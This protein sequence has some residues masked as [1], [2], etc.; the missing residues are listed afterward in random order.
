MNTIWKLISC[1]LN[2]SIIRV[3]FAEKINVFE[4]YRCRFWPPRYLQNIP[5]DKKEIKR[6]QLKLFRLKHFL[7]RSLFMHIGGKR[8]S[9]TNVLKW[10]RVPFV[11]PTPPRPPKTLHLKFTEKSQL[12]PPPEFLTTF[13][14]CG[15]KCFDVLS[16]LGLRIKLHSTV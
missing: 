13:H 3:K 6:I 11:Q 5:I 10:K 8:E 9:V 4:S 16:F 14:H 15:R 7:G 2:V 12:S 1:E